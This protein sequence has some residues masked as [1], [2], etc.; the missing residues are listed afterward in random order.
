MFYREPITNVSTSSSCSGFLLFSFHIL[1]WKWQLYKCYYYLI[2]SQSLWRELL[3]FTTKRSSF[4]LRCTPPLC[5]LFHFII[6]RRSGK[7]LSATLREQSHEESLE[8]IIFH[9]LARLGT[10]NHSSSGTFTLN[11]SHP[12]NTP[13]PQPLLLGSISKTTNFNG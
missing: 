8:C 9:F 2:V 7:V 10:R 5:L 6:L 12:L 4:V 3:Y 11:L 13:S 1:L